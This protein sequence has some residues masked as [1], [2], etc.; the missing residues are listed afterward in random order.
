M[1]G[2]AV[3]EPN[4][5]VTVASEDGRAVVRVC[6]EVDLATAPQLKRALDQ[7]LA[8]S[9][10]DAR[11][12]PVV[13]EV[14]GVTFLDACGLGVLAGAAMRARRRGSA[15]ILRDASRRI[16]QVLEITRLVPVFGLERSDHRRATVTLPPRPLHLEVA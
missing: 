16:M 15:L 13:V 12:H 14:S 6:G 9:R 2:R 4:F 10:R 7:A 3:L 11:G 8:V 1:D 5:G